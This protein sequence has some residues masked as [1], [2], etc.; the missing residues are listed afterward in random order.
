MRPTCRA[1]AIAAAS[2]FQQW[3]SNA[4][5]DAS[6]AL[7]RCGSCCCLLSLRRATSAVFHLRTAYHT[8]AIKSTT[9]H[10]LTLPLPACA[11]MHQRDTRA[12]CHTPAFTRQRATHACHTAHAHAYLRLH[13]PASHARLPHRTYAHDIPPPSRAS[14]PRTPAASNAAKA[15]FVAQG[16]TQGLRPPRLSRSGCRRFQHVPPCTNATHAHSATPPPSRASKSRTSPHPAASNAALGV[17]HGAR[18][19]ARRLPAETVE[20]GL[21]PFPAC[22]AMHQRDTRAPCHIPPSRTCKSRTPATSHMRTTYP[23]LH[24]PASHARL[25]HRTRARIPSPS[26]ASKP[27]T[28]ATPHRRTHTASNAA[29]ASFVAQ[30]ETYGLA[31]RDS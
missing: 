5:A 7:C 19:G 25:P 20:I 3:I 29:R 24:A 12:L 16:G 18:W 22:A 26:R 21:P 15:S 27:R 8:R 1:R 2:S 23:R 14:E 17:A 28:P 30:G 13:A 6:A 31:R 9:T 11:A 4:V 10:V